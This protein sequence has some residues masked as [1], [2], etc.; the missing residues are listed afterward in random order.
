MSASQAC[1]AS[2]PSVPK[3]LKPKLMECYFKLDAFPD[4]RAML[5]YAWDG[6]PLPSATRT[7]TSTWPGE[8]LST[9]TSAMVA[10]AERAWKR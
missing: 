4:A 1:L 9:E 3:A 7:V 2:M 10:S 5:A 6:V 8:G